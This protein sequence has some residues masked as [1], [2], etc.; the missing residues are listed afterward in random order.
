VAEAEGISWVG[1]N[2]TAAAPDGV[3]VVAMVPNGVSKI[4]VTSA[5]GST[6]TVDV[7]NNMADDTTQTNVKEYRYTMPDGKV[8]TRRGY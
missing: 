1:T 7:A 3:G 6:S 8:V 4:E 5:N 2:S